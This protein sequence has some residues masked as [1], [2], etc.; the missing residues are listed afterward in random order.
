HP[1]TIDRELARLTIITAGLRLCDFANCNLRRWRNSA[2]GGGHPLL[3]P[4]V[5]GGD[6][7]EPVD[8]LSALVGNPQDHGGDQ[9]VI[10]IALAIAS[11]IVRIEDRREVPI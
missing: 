1:P 6:L 9:G 11:E 4:L 8:V 3:P 2:S 10:P 5:R 7:H